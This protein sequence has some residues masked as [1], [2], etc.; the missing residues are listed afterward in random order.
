LANR[1]FYSIVL[2]IIGLILA[3]RNSG[4]IGQ[5][6]TFSRVTAGEIVS[7]TASSPSASWNDIDGDGDDDLYV[8][9]GFGSL[10]DPPV[11][12]Q[13]R[14]YRNDGGGQFTALSDHPLVREVT[15]SG[16]SIWGD[17]DND[18]DT[19]LF[20]ANQQGADNHLYRNEGDTSFT[21]VTGGR[22]ASDGG[23]SF[24]A[25]W[26]DIDRDGLIDLHVLNGRDSPEGERDFLYRN[27]GGCQ[28]ERM[29]DVALTES[30]YPSGGASW[31]DYDRDG[32]PDVVV[33]VHS[34]SENFRLYRN[35]GNWTFTDVSESLEPVDEPLPYS[36]ATSVAHW[37][38][39]D[40][41]LDFDLFIGNVG[42]VDY[43]FVNDGS[44]RFTKST[45][46]RLGLD[47]TYVSDVV[48]ADFDNDAD[49]D[50]VIAVWGGASEYYENSG[51]GTFRQADAGDLG[52]VLNFASSVSANDADGD[53]D[54]DLY[55]TH[56]PI[57]EAGGE[58]NQF[59]LNDSPGGNWLDIS[60]EGNGSNRSAIGAL[61]VVTAEI[62]G[63]RVNQLRQVDARTSWRSTGSL[64]Q[65]F[66]LGDA[67]TIESIEVLWPSGNRNRMTVPVASNQRITIKEG[68]GITDVR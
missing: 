51:D 18:G 49:L 11:P 40:N 46:G 4:K 63:E 67:E 1:T 36:P 48:W 42:T 24:S 13:N 58:P 65:H 20:V 21:R 16:S 31:V 23:R 19:D 32:D 14:L 61:V 55:L 43:L 52:S 3:C 59:Y 17:C 5:G 8:L 44:G 33:P 62:R 2:A 47:A 38:D 41:D 27:L 66:G 53:G 60:L 25:T 9:N 64:I 28:F 7:D 12:Q 35:D 54:M 45:A 56:W 26:V 34:S 15:F 39:Y 68:M 22:I 10:E 6:A 50:Y 57:N 37:I 29:D 30:I